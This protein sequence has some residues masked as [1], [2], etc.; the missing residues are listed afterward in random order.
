MENITP[1]SV[2][3]VTDNLIKTSNSFEKN[4]LATSLAVITFVLVGIIIFLGYQNNEM[5]K[6]NN[7]MTKVA[8]QTA[9]QNQIQ[10][11]TI[12]VQSA[13]IDITTKKL[14]DSTNVKK[15]KKLK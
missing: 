9:I 8:F 1:P 13:A 12:K 7:E 5:Q 4:P 15:N 10:K 3:E 14:Q 11:Q 6:A 2:T